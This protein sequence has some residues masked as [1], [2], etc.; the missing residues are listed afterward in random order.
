MESGRDPLPFSAPSVSRHTE[1]VPCAFCG[2][3]ERLS[4]EHTLPAW[5]QPLLREPS[6]QEGTHHRAVL[7]VDDEAPATWTERP[8]HPATTT[9]RSVCIG[10]NNGWM[11]RLEAEAKPFLTT[12][13]RGHGRTY[14]ERGATVIATWLIKT[15]LVAGSKFE[16]RL[17]A[18]VY[19]DFYRDQSPSENTRIWLGLSAHRYQHYTDFRPFR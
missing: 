9:V 5:M 7:R 19:H 1:R 8:G 15:A 6:E 14:Y 4:G 18:T 11:A 17:P 10:C 13:I 2:S 12:M 3:S 16:P